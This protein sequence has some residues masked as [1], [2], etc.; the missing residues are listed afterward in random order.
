MIRPSGMG[1][2]RRWIVLAACASAAVAAAAQQEGA[3]RPAAQFDASAIRPS[4]PLEAGNLRVVPGLMLPGGRWIASNVTLLMLLQRAYPEY[5]QEGRIV[6]GPS[7]VSSRRFEVTAI[8]EAPGDERGVRAMVRRLLGDRFRLQ[9]RTDVRVMD[10]YALVRSR[11]DGRLG[12]GLTASTA[13]CETV[14]DQD[15]GRALDPVAP[16]E[17]PDEPPCGTTGAMVD[18]VMR[19][20]SGNAT[21]SDLAALLQAWV[22]RPV[23]DR[24]GLEGRYDARLAFDPA[25]LWNGPTASGPGAPAFFTAV[26]EQ[27]GFR[28]EPRR[29]RMEVLVIEHAELPAP[30]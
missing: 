26:Q 20:W 30:D 7:W 12:P 8:T 23:R 16:A 27:L 4:P 24:T 18:G 10:V 29:E 14:R 25:S 11:R 3:E 9:L 13:S 21:P 17:P 5:A 2:L 28:L 22:D 19:V 6:G 1:T 15:A